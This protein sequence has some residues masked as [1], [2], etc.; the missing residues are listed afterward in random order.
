[1]SRAQRRRDD[2]R[3]VATAAPPPNPGAHLDWKRSG[4]GAWQRRVASAALEAILADEDEHGRLVP[5]SP[6]ACSRGV[7]WLDAAL[8]A[9]SGDLRRGFVAITILLEWLPLVVIGAPGRMSRLPLERRIAY[10]TALES[11]RLGVFSM[12]LVAFKVPLCIPAFEEGE[13]LRSTGFDRPSTSARRRLP[14]A[15]PVEATP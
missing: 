6:D 2:A 15:P 4:L 10:L 1:M 7:D 14:Q 3:P 12:L 11:S 9:G 13:E 5:A 8:G